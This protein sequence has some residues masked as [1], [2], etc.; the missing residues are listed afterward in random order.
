MRH[1]KILSAVCVLTLAAASVSMTADAEGLEVIE[2]KT[3][4][5]HFIQ[6]DV[7]GKAFVTIP[8]GI[9]ADVSIAYESPEYDA[10][11]YYES[12][13]EGG[14]TY[15]FDLEGRDITADD[16]RYYTISVELTGGVYNLT[17]EAY[18]DTF[19]IPDGND[20]PDSFREISY[21][22]TVDGEESDNPWD[23]P[24]DEDNVKEIAVHLDY[25][26][27]GDINEDGTIDSS[28]ASL[29]LVEYSALS[30]GKETTLTAKGSIVADVNKDNTIDSSDAS[31]ILL[32]YSVGS[33]GETPSWDNI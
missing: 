18:T 14:A 12:V 33:T 25:V 10:H 8:E 6:T 29:A 20:N 7:N 13:L 4:C 3:I 26:K 30:T 15:S 1:F 2:V 11:P 19:K 21:T 9:T 27:L 32:Y 5:E 16:Y 28:D 24:V 31:K 17:S 23:M 22:F